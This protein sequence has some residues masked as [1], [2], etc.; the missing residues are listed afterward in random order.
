MDLSKLIEPL[1]E[2]GILDAIRSVCAGKTECYLVGGAIR[3]YLT[4]RKLNDFDFC[5]P[6]HASSYAE[7][8]ARQLG[9]TWFVLDEQR[10]HSRL[11]IKRV[12]RKLTC[13]FALFRAPSLESDLR[14]RDFTIN[15]MAVSCHH[16]DPK[17]IDPLRGQAD[18]AARILRSCS[19]YSFQEDPLR[20]LKGV[21]HAVNLGF[22]FDPETLTRLIET[23]PQIDQIASERIRSEL[24]R[25]IAGVPSTKTFELLHATGLDRELFGPTSAASFDSAIDKVRS[26]ESILKALMTGACGHIITDYIDESCEED[27]SIGVALKLSAFLS[28]YR[29]VALKSVL[30]ALR[31]SRRT[32]SLV[33]QL[34]RLGSDTVAECEKV[35]NTPRSRARWLS[36]T[37]KEPLATAVF[38]P[39]VWPG[40]IRSNLLKAELLIDSYS[41]CQTDGRLDELVDGTWMAATLGVSE[42][43][44]VG[45][46]LA[47]LHGAEIAGEVTTSADA[48]KWLIENHKSID[49]DFQTSL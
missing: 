44:G 1:Q 12:D 19:D 20:C 9:A 16:N 31:F 11:V 25:S 35:A 43:P 22:D 33:E 40:E 10:E 42:G 14:K 4:N 30:N 24:S 5:F 29:P 3:D 26:M 45:R 27:V 32:I 13:D 46:L 2:N 49:N 41:R 38:M 37:G 48:Q 18:L 47:L 8:I 34:V 36:G 7:K 21:R 28:G 6:E 15:A 23:A 39:L 17:L